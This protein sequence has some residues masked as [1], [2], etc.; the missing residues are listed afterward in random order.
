M[1]NSEAQYLA[2]NAL[3]SV[4]T[5]VTRTAVLTTTAIIFLLSFF[6]THASAQ[7]GRTACVPGSGKENFPFC[8]V[9]L[10]IDDRVR[11]LISRIPNSVKP[12]LLTARGP[13]PHD[14]SSRQALPHLGVPAYY[15]GQSEFLYCCSICPPRGARSIFQWYFLSALFVASYLHMAALSC[16]F[17]W[18]LH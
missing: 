5:S 2:N 11:D 8:N 18:G 17:F 13:N 6:P 1:R 15:W 4:A 10:P 16:F 12:A 7:A 14:P 9:S 3:S